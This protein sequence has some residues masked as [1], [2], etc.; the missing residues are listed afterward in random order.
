[1]IVRSPSSLLLVVVVVGWG[2]VGFWHVPLAAHCLLSKDGYGSGSVRISAGFGSSMFGFGANFEPT[3][4]RVRISKRLPVQ[5]RSPI[6]PVEHHLGPKTI[7]PINS[8]SR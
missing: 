5:G 2:G 4:F 1:M 7:E 3:D 6:S 8:P